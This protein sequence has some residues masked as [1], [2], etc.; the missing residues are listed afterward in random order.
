MSPL[1][2]TMRT[3]YR[4]WSRSNAVP[5]FPS[6][7]KRSGSF[8]PLRNQLRSYHTGQDRQLSTIHQHQ[9]RA[10]TEA[11]ACPGRSS[12][13]L[14]H[15]PWSDQKLG[16]SQRPK[17]EVHC[18]RIQHLEY[19]DL[20]LWRAHKELGYDADWVALKVGLSNHCIECIC[21]SGF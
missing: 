19:L 6:C 4:I 5:R 12:W 16:Q 7:T 9:A 21:K 2:H 10:R 1:P 8:L 14:A 13:R 17:K 20:L 15:V 3:L 18:Y 11:E